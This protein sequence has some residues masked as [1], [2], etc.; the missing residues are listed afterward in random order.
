[1]SLD[2]CEVAICTAVTGGEQ[3]ALVP[4]F[5]QRTKDGFQGGE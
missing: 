3:Q 5:I 2:G 4:V 1:M